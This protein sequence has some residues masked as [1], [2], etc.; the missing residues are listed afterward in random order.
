MTRADDLKRM[1]D[2]ARHPGES[3]KAYRNRRVLAQASVDKHLKGRLVFESTRFVAIPPKGDPRAKPPTEDD[4][5]T[6]EHILRGQLRDVQMVG[7]KRVARTK[8]K[9][10]RKESTA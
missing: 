2:N 10:Y 1:L 8:G 4:P 9:T 7:G 6:E 5:Q 3:F